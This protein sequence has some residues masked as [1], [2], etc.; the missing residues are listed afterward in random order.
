[1]LAEN[2]IN[3]TDTFDSIIEKV[4]DILEGE[5]TSFGKCFSIS[6]L[7]RPEVIENMEIPELELIPN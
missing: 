2:S 3:G 6:E 4:K 5:M 7:L 1:M